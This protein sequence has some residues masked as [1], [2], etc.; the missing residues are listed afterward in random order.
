MAMEK[1]RRKMWVMPIRKGGN[2]YTVHKTIPE[3][4][5]VWKNMIPPL[6]PLFDV[7]KARYEIMLP[8]PHKQKKEYGYIASFFSQQALLIPN[9][10]STM[11][12]RFPS[13]IFPNKS[14][15]QPRKT[16][17]RDFGGDERDNNEQGDQTPS[18]PSHS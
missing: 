8:H 3:R 11:T 16:Q 4:D 12:H 18:F 14:P 15:P 2:L 1:G 6:P 5:C 13:P 10:S 9:K 7:Y 17:T